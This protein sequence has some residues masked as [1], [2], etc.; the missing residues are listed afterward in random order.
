MPNKLERARK[1]FTPLNI[2][3]TEI[4]DTENRP[5]E[6]EEKE[7]SANRAELLDINQEGDALIC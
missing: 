4:M 1:E 3:K 5:D 6:V 7:I 2:D